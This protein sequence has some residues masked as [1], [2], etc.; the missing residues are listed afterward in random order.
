MDNTPDMNGDGVVTMTD[1]IQNY[2]NGTREEITEDEQQFKNKFYEFKRKY[3]TYS[4]NGELENLEK[5]YNSW[6]EAETD[7]EKKT[8]RANLESYMLELEKGST[9]S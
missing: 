3:R 5:L 8:A 9:S 7:S 4:P 2:R 1:V 6:N